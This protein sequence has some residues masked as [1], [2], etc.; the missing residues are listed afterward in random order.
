M[1]ANYPLKYVKDLLSQLVAKC[2]LQIQLDFHP[3]A[4]LNIFHEKLSPNSFTGNSY[5]QQRDNVRPLTLAPPH[6]HFSSFSRPSTLVL[7][8]YCLFTVYLWF[9]YRLPVFYKSEVLVIWHDFDT[10]YFRIK[11]KEPT[12]IKEQYRQAHKQTDT[13]AA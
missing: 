8:H 1:D 13:L 4:K 12:H 10:I 3:R 5:S 11:R 6:Y 2:E 9:C 7:S